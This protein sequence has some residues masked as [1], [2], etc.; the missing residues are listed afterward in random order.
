MVVVGGQW[1]AGGAIQGS[2]CVRQAVCKRLEPWAAAAAAAVAGNSRGR[3]DRAAGVYLAA[4]GAAC[5]SRGQGEGRGEA[6]LLVVVGGQWPAG[7]A[8]QGSSCVR[9]AVCKWLEPWAA[10]ATTAVAGTP[11]GGVD[12]TR[13]AALCLAAAGAACC[14]R[15][16][17]GGGRGGPLLVV[18]VGRAV[19]SGWVQFVAHAVCK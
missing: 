13:A 5:C 2:S 6:L 8:I 18:V 12:C 19:A 15:G 16:V 3:V 11:R 4:A 9:Q 1:Q 14:G 17:V 10:A 7:G